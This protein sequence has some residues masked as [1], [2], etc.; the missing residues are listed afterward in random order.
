MAKTISDNGLKLIKEF[1]GLRLDAYK[2]VPTEE[3]Y[4]IGYGHYGKDVRKD[5]HITIEQAE[6]YLKDDVQSAV[7]AV[8]RLGRLWNQN[9]FDAL[10]SF[11]YN[12]GQKNLITLCKDR[13]PDVIAEKLLLYCKSNGKVLIG[14]KR[15][16]QAERNLFLK[17]CFT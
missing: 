16:R 2:C 5:M 9:Q 17:K 3:F 10:V 6:R 4:T 12:C 8:N 14:L 1:E 11:T 15:R 7:K 13:T